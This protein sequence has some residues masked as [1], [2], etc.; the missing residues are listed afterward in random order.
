MWLAVLAVLCVGLAVGLMF[1]SAIDDA[2][3]K[4]KKKHRPPAPLTTLWANINHDGLTPSHK[5]LTGNT[6]TAEGRY[7]ISFNRDVSQCAK[8]ATIHSR[9]GEVVLSDRSDSPN[10]VFVE[11]VTSDHSEWQD[12][13]FALVVNC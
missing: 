1:G 12:A 10:T 8:V 13:Q 5:G 2:E 3:A 7:A 6:R 9:Y 11:I 4:K